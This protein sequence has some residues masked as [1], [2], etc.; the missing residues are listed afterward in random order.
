MLKRKM[1]SVINR[2]GLTSHITYQIQPY[3]MT[4]SSLDPC[5]EKS[6]RFHFDISPYKIYCISNIEQGNHWYE[7]ITATYNYG[8]A[9]SRLHARPLNWVILQFI[10]VTS[11]FYV[12]CVPCMDAQG[13]IQFWLWNMNYGSWRTLESAATV[14]ISLYIIIIERAAW[15]CVH[16]SRT[17]YDP[18]WER[19]N[20]KKWALVFGHCNLPS[21]L[22]NSFII[23]NI[24]WK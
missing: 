21:L 6:I 2:P 17:Q 15:N 14:I 3:L 11:T 22:C 16:K 10:N 19:F 1:Q 5:N 8:Y 18:I 13:I 12:W 7:W 20:G 4:Q 24:Q 9:A 23:M